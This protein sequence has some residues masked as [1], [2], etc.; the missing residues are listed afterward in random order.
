VTPDRTKEAVW[1]SMAACMGLPLN[2][3]F[4]PSE[5]DYD[6]RP[7]K[8]ICRACPVR[9]DCLEYALE[10]EQTTALHGVWGGKSHKERV[11]LLAQKRRNR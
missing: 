4:G 1:R 6:P 2:V 9:R 3:F 5:G 11:E 8:A 7:A 10:V